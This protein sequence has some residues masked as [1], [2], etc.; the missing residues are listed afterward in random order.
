[1]IANPP[2][3]LAGLRLSFHLFIFPSFLFILSSFLS[4]CLR[5]SVRQVM[6]MLRHFMRQPLLPIDF[7]FFMYYLCIRNKKHIDVAN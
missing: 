3:R 2:E 5:Q 7:P 1:M 6:R 4:P